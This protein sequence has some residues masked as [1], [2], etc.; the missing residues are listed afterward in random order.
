MILTYEVAD[1]SPKE[2]QQAWI[3]FKH[4]TFRI[5]W[6]S[7]LETLW[8]SRINFFCCYRKCPLGP[9][10]V[11]RCGDDRIV[12]VCV[13]QFCEESS[14]KPYPVVTIPRV[15]TPQVLVGGW[16]PRTFRRKRRSELRLL[17]MTRS[18]TCDPLPHSGVGTQLN[19]FTTWFSYLNWLVL[20]KFC[21]CFPILGISSS[22][23]TNSYFSEGWLNRHPDPTSWN[24]MGK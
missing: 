5:C 7:F 9:W 1:V 24:A 4:I 2:T 19:K 15:L 8:N 10:T 13:F 16:E 14:F 23:L 22:Q 21:L 12:L 11:D 18:V 20:W 3:Q 17:F 6:Q